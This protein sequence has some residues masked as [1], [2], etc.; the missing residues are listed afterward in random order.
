MRRLAIIIIAASLFPT[1]AYAHPDFSHA[2]GVLA[3][4]GHP[5]NGL[6]HVLA[7][8]AVGVL[9]AVLGGRAL[10]M[11]PL[12]FLGIMIAGFQLGKTG[13]DLPFVE[14]SIALSSVMIGSLAAM[15]RP[16]PAAA[17]AALV[18]VF[19]LFHGYA[20][21]TE[22]P[23]NANGTPYVVGFIAATAVLHLMGIGAAIGSSRL[24]GRYGSLAART[25]ASG[26]ALGGLGVLLGWI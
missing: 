21:G 13:T 15:G 23:V 22:I 8:V 5:L 6:D 20:H 7:M 18:G 2:G 14:L 24:A 10:L 26:L 3:G 11:V 1:A 17:A 16:I 12:S 25:A 9:A 4:F 19:G